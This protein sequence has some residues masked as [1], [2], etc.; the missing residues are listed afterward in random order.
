MNQVLPLSVSSPQT[1]P[2]EKGTASGDDD[3][4]DENSDA[5]CE[6]L[7]DSDSEVG[8]SDES[9]IDKELFGGSSVLRRARQEARQRSKPT[10]DEGSNSF[11]RNMLR[12]FQAQSRTFDAVATALTTSSQS[13]NSSEIKTNRDL[14]SEI[15]SIQKAKET[16]VYDE[17]EA[18]HQ[19][20]K[21]KAALKKYQSTNA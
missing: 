5:S 15:E 8:S 6:V 13:K 20:E 10:S 11:Q 7:G 1:A 9:C 21:A 4:D 2:R 14:M 12:Q 16:G 18:A 19:I 17:A 3:D